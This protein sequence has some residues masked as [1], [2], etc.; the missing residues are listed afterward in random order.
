MQRWDLSGQGNDDAAGKALDQDSIAGPLRLARLRGSLERAICGSRDIINF[1][2]TCLPDKN[3][4][5]RDRAAA[6]SHA[7]FWYCF[8][9]LSHFLRAPIRSKMLPGRWR[10]RSQLFRSESAVFF[11]LGRIIPRWQTSILK[12][13]RKPLRMNSAVRILLRSKNQARMRS[14][15]P[16][17]RHRH[18]MF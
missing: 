3:C 8:S 2:F 9:F 13:C 18:F 16:S 1:V 14:R 17:K 6:F 7:L 4:P 11:C 15:F 12:R 10:A 5:H